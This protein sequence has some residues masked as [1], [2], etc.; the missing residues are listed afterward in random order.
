MFLILICQYVCIV[1]NIFVSLVSFV[2]VLGFRLNMSP[3]VS[4]YCV[5]LR[6][7]GNKSQNPKTVI[8]I[9]L[10]AA[11]VQLYWMFL[12]FKQLQPHKQ[13]FKHFGEEKMKNT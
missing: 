12:Y 13:V 10:K 3:E 8:F 7:V 2:P 4:A 5:L 1:V 11:K 9:H 6:S